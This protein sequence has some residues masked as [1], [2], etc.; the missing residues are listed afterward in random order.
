[1]LYIFTLAVFDHIFD[2]F[3]Y[4]TFFLNL[5]FSILFKFSTCAELRNLVFTKMREN[6]FLC[7]ATN[8]IAISF[9]PISILCLS[10]SKNTV[11]FSTYRYF[12]LEKIC[13]LHIS[14]VLFLPHWHGHT[15]TQ[16]MP[17]YATGAQLWVVIVC[18]H[19]RKS[20]LVS[21]WPVIWML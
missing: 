8:N 19:L 9:P 7:C 11:F 21:G 10:F 13:T 2:D 18:A 12:N 15:L 5:I 3:V 14:Q 4:I 20:P 17:N 6:H 16:I 1:M